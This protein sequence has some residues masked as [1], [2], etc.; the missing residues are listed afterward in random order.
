[1]DAYRTGRGSI[2]MRAMAEIVETATGRP[3]RGHRAPLPD[4]RSSSIEEQIAELVNAGELDG[5]ARR[6]DDSAGRHDPPRHRR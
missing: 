6:Q 3:D 1:M 4:R 2:K 5:I